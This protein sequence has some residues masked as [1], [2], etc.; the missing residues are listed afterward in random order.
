MTH[1]ETTTR[2]AS[3]SPSI[4]DPTYLPEVCRL[5]LD[6]IIVLPCRMQLDT[7]AVTATVP[8]LRGVWG[9]A[10]HE[11]FPELYGRVFDVGSS[12]GSIAVSPPYIVRAAPPFPEWVP[13]VEVIL[14]AEAIEYRDELHKCWVYASR[15]GLGKSREPFEIRRREVVLA[16]ESTAIDGCAWALSHSRWPLPADAPCRLV[17]PV[18]LRLRRR[19]RLIE[20]PTLADLVA[21]LNRRLAGYLPERYRPFWLQLGRQFLEIARATPQQAWVGDRLDLV[22]YSGRQKSELDLHGVTGALRLPHGPGP[23]LPLL[24]A[25]QWLHIGKNTVMGMGQLMVE[26]VE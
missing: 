13:A 5:L 16:D 20:S 12:P 2:S 10:I 9:K 7:R 25:A 26:P 6:H 24:A 21:S 1:S 15:E 8:M 17:F 22:R 18:P 4:C 19:G 3:P 23:L 14:I 11:L